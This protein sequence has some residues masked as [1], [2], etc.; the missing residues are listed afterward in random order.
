MDKTPEQD[1]T[2]IEQTNNTDAGAKNPER[3][4][5]D[6]LWKDLIDRFF[7]HILEMVLPDL[8]IDADTSKQHSFLDKEF[9]D[10]LNTADP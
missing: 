10:I 6:S 5:H 4:D 9:R 1:A 3:F 8:Y 2:L 7:W